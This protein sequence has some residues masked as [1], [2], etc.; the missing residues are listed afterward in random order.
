[1]SPRA[2]AKTSPRRRRRSK[3]RA[4]RLSAP[5][6]TQEE[7][8]VL[9]P[10]ERLKPSQ[11]AE[12]YRILGRGQSDIPGRWN[13]RVAPYLRG[14]MDLAVAP[15]VIRLDICKGAQGGIS[16]A[17]RNLMAFW[18]DTDPDP[19][20]LTLPD[21][22]H[23]RE[24]VRMRILPLFTRTPR[25]ARWLTQ[26][27]H[28]VKSGRLTLSNGFTLHLMWSGSA[29]SM[30]S[31]L[32]RR[33]INDE[34]DKHKPW[35]G[36]EPDS[37]AQTAAR[38]TT[39]GLRSMQV[40][41]STPTTRMGRIWRLV[42]E[43]GVRLYY[44]V[45]CPRCGRRQRLIFPQLKW[46][47]HGKYQTKDL[48]RLAELLVA[49]NAVWYECPHCKGRIEPAEQAEMVRQGRWGTLDG[50]I[51]D[52]EAVPSW[53]AGTR[54]GMEIGG[55]YWI[56]DERQWAT[57]VARFLE[58]QGDPEKMFSFRTLVLGEP[59]E[60]R[61]ARTS[62]G[63][64]SAKC[65]RATLAEGL[66]PRWAARL[67]A[68]VDTQHDHFYAVLRA[69]GPQGL[70][71]RVW[72]GKPQTFADLERILLQ[73]PWPVEE[74]AAP[75]MMADLVLIDSGGTQLEGEPVSRTREVYAWVREHPGRVRCIK[76]ADRPDKGLWH[77]LSGGKRSADRRALT[78][79]LWYIV[80]NHYADMLQEAIDHG[81]P[82]RARPE[83]E[84]R[85]ETAA[86]QERWLLNT[87]DDPE[88]NEHL[89]SVAK[90]MIRVRGLPKL[91]W[92]PTYSGARIDY[93]DCE[94]YLLAA[95]DMLLIHLLPP[96]PEFLALRQE[97]EQ[98]RH[99][100]TAASRRAN[101]PSRAAWQPR[102]F[103]GLIR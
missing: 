49:D 18:A 6:W 23:G 16:E 7:R 86:D 87:R 58:A 34:V 55:L 10:P 12:R 77:W 94:R 84:P 30:A 78:P 21:R 73:T 50:S 8:E 60:D 29:S 69:F 44:L 62:S 93:W 89:A 47:R 24:I 65:G 41:V 97:A 70:S 72:H 74:S 48:H 9:R 91:D 19:C 100:T 52:A 51:L 68:A 42:E 31:D 71:Q 26:R 33:V 81:R 17:T 96:L 45:P 35:A 67:A 66:V 103:G 83:G 38:M 36:R 2:A 88:Y 95:A 15:G 101:A 14:M 37:V 20:G 22:E 13:N 32:M 85:A 46:A 98:A 54:I 1:M 80:R 40:N 61:R 64:F 76:G 82:D 56:W 5:V 11:W 102:D 43:D 92:V 99:A 57:V 53:P 59:Y 39:Y 27:K 3:P 28:D 75:P 90:V 63:V 25:L 4:T 79:P